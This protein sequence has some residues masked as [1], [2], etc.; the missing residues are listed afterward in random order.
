[1][2]CLDKM[3]KNMNGKMTQLKPGVKWRTLLLTSAMLWTLIGIMLLTRGVLRLNNVMTGRTLIVF[4]ALLAGTLKSRYVLDQSARKGVERILSFN[5]G[6][7]LGA[8]YSIRTW[9][10]VLCMMALGVILRSS[11]LPDTALS[12]FYLVIGW[13]LLFSSRVSWFAWWQTR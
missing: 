1:M 11:S 9:I 3:E 5:D 8:V 7:C 13:A 4:G 10:L 12:F 2:F 6:T